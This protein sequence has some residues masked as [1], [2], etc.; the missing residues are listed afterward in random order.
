MRAVR[1]SN[2]L[3]ASR[4]IQAYPLLEQLLD[5]SNLIWNDREGFHRREL[6][7]FERDED[8]PPAK[9]LGRQR[10]LYHYCSA[11]APGR[12]RVRLAGIADPQGSEHSGPRK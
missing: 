3:L 1:A 2:G 5:L 11:W 9:S 8:T 10:Q 7:E 4:A 12:R 6:R